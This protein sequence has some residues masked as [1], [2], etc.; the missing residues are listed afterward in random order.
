MESVT[1]SDGVVRKQCRKDCKR[2][3]ESIF[4]NGNY[5]AGIGAGYSIGGIAIVSF[6]GGV[7]KAG[8]LGFDGSFDMIR[9]GPILR[10]YAIF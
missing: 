2:N 3:L 1:G 4:G 10:F 8:D 6:G 9:H 7:D 5:R